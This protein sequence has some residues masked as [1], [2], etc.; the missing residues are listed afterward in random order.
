MSDAWGYDPSFAARV[1]PLLDGLYARWWRVRVSGAGN[2]PATGP[3]IVA[4]NHAGLLP[5]SE[6]MVVQALRREHPAHV[7][8]R[9]L[10]PEWA[11]DVPF[12]SVALRRLGGVPASPHNALRLLAE[13]H[14]VV[15]FPE[16]DRAVAKPWSRRHRVER[17][18]S[19]FVELALRAGA[20]IV[21]CA[22]LGAEEAYP[23]LRAVRAPVL[24]RL[25][26]T[27]HLPLTPT[28]PWL[29]PLG[30][31]PL[32]ARWR[33]AFGAPVHLTGEGGARGGPEAAGDRR[34]VLET[35]EAVHDL[36]QAML[37]ENVVKREGAYV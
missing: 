35:A 16:G 32:P 14:V 29:G 2:V 22:V 31:V 5:V 30:L 24:R 15:V 28:F 6:A 34:L 9:F 19:G 1:A 3:A 20:P 33:I 18:G 11:F 10:A 26:G 12:L 37:Y 23:Q 17:F 7:A 27:P 4:A 21:P 8:A 13:G 25:V 36:V